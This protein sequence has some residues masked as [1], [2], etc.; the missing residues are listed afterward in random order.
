MYVSSVWMGRNGRVLPGKW[1]LIPKDGL[2]REGE[3]GAEKEAR[4]AAVV[5]LIASNSAAPL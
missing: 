3:L 5:L 2:A 1:I 4:G